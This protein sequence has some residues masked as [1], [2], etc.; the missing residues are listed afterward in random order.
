VRVQRTAAQYSID[1]NVVAAPL[2]SHG[3]FDWYN[4]P[5]SAT[6]TYEL[7][8]CDGPPSATRGGRY[9]LLPVVKRQLAQNAIILMDDVERPDE[10]GIIER[11]EKQFNV[12]CEEHRT[13]SGVYAIVKA[14]R[15]AAQEAVI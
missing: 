8:I 12:S 14:V 2:V 9:G 11:W 5:Q 13:T 7:V 4:L 6:N 1:I 15:G 10:R 3:L